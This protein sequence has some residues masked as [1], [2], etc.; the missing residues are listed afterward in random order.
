MTQK[1]T[2]KMPVIVVKKKWY[3]L[4]V[5]GQKKQEYRKCSPRNIE[6]SFKIADALDENGGECQ[7]KFALGYNSDRPE[8]IKTITDVSYTNY[9]DTQAF[10]A[11]W[12]AAVQEG[13]NLLDMLR[14][15]LGDI[16]VYE[17]K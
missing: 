9:E 15:D 7:V 2:Q 6:Q 1:M 13:G 10:N 17:L 11:R 14:E 12:D 16:I 8:I 3:D 5:S 4:I